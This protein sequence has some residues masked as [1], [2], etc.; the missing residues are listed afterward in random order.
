MASRDFRRMVEAGRV[1]RN[2]EPRTRL[3]FHAASGADGGKYL[4]GASALAWFGV[5]A[6]FLCVSQ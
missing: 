4:R 2:S 6:S 1:G 5:N 3:T